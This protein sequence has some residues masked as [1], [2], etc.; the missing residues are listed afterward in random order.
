MRTPGAAR[1]G[2]AGGGGLTARGLA[3]RGLTTLR[4][5][6]FGA[7]RLTGALRAGLRARFTIFLRSAGRLAGAFLR[8]DLALTFFRV[9]M[10]VSLA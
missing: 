1:S 3:V 7:A 5:A 2:A 4:L 9:A 8:F 10:R 6:T